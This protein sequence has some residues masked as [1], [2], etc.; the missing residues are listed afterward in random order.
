MSYWSYRVKKE[1]ARRER[2]FSLGEDVQNR[3]TPRPTEPKTPGFRLPARGSN[4]AF[5][6]S[7]DL[8]SLQSSRAF[9]VTNAAF[10]VAIAARE[11]QMNLLSNQRDATYPATNLRLSPAESNTDRERG[12]GG[13][14]LP[15]LGRKQRLR[16]PGSHLHR[17]SQQPVE[18]RR[19]ARATC[20]ARIF[21]CPSWPTTSTATVA[22]TRESLVCSAV[23]E[24]GVPCAAAKNAWLPCSRNPTGSSIGIMPST[25]LPW[26]AS[27]CST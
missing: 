10:E 6:A 14:T 24:I 4:A 20:Q 19:V 17:A 5:P 16:L 3:P 2:A 7:T 1:K 13:G 26:A 8:L 9:E 12:E 23:V 27:P 25:S 18:R 11:P 22:V 15:R 21:G